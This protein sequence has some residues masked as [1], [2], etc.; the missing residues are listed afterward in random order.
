MVI[1]NVKATKLRHSLSCTDHYLWNTCSTYDKQT[2]NRHD[3]HN[4]PLICGS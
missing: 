3:E 1:G 2:E 4:M